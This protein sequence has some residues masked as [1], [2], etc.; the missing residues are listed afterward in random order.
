MQIAKIQ[1]MTLRHEPQ[2][3]KSKSI[4][5]PSPLTIHP[6]NPPATKKKII[7]TMIPIIPNISIT[8]YLFV[9]WHNIVTFRE[10]F[11]KQNN[12][13]YQ[14]YVFITFTISFNTVIHSLYILF[15]SDTMSFTDFEY[16][17][18]ILFEIEK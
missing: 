9:S 3:L 17:L 10:K 14:G 13:F 6:N 7:K 11:K 15:Q 1:K 8:Y 4:T 12:I 2:P 18:G 5:T 16:Q